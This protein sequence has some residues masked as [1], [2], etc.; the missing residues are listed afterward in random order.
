MEN[1]GLIN[2]VASSPPSAKSD[3]KEGRPA[4]VIGASPGLVTSH[5]DSPASVKEVG[6]K[7]CDGCKSAISIACFSCEKVRFRF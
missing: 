2:Y 1:W 5:V 6:K 4:S 3:E 7:V